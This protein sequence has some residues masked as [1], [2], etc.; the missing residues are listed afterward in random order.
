MAW[1]IVW[2]LGHG[3]AVPSADV[4]LAMKRKGRA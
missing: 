4:I 3:S 2:L 1:L